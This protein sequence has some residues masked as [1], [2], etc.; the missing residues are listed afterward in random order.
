MSKTIL[1]TGASTGIGA[2][3]ALR[4]APGN[5]LILHHNRSPIDEV[6]AEAVARGATAVHTTRADLSVESGCQSMFADV[7]SLTGHLDVLVNNA[8]SLL[9]R[10]TVDTLRW[11]LMEKIFSLNT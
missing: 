4:L 6:A 9:E 11:E 7:A 2:V 3:A 5:P 1:I 10:H 8:G